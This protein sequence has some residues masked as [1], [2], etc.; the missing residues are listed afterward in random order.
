LLPAYEVFCCRKKALQKSFTFYV[1][2]FFI[3][4]NIQLFF[5]S[6]KEITFAFATWKDLRL[7]ATTGKNAKA[8]VLFTF[9]IQS[10]HPAA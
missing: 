10:I 5:Y 3:K 8:I 7:I 4:K 2:P 1:K 6:V 9:I